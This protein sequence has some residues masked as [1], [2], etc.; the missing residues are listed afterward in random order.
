MEK[1]V[2]STNIAGTNGFPQINKQINT[3]LTLT[4]H[5]T[6]ILT[7]NGLKTKS[8]KSRHSRRNI[9]ENLYSLKK[10]KDFLGYKK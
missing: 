4:Q 10:D 7:W 2:L 8:W 5:K 1:V 6:L 9:G 3:R